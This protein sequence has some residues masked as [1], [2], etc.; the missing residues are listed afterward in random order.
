M[1]PE[2]WL[3]GFVQ[4]RVRQQIEARKSDPSWNEAVASY[5]NSGGQ[6]LTDENVLCHGLTH[7]IFANASDRHE[8]NMAELRRIQ[9]ARTHHAEE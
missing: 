1:N 3:Q 5:V 9:E 8:I 2:E 6:D 7:S 4:L